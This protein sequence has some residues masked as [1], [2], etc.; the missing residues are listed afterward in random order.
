MNVI[1]KNLIVLGVGILF[2]TQNVFA[3]TS[4]TINASSYANSGE[5]PGSESVARV[6]IE[7]VVDG[8]VVQSVHETKTTSGSAYI[9]K[10]IEYEA[11]NT[12][13]E[14]QTAASYIA[15]YIQEVE[16]V[17]HV[18]D[19]FQEEVLSVPQVVLEPKET[20]RLLAMLNNF[21]EYVFTFIK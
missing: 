14:V 15:E 20:S 18:E 1:Q 4:I 10:N 9:E 21:F 8:E 13:V 17:E 2:C 6:D 3:S 5:L 12:L 7:T 11:E 16:L 19:I